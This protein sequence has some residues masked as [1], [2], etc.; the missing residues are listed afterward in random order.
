MEFDSVRVPKEITMIRYFREGLKL[1]IKAE[2]DQRGREFNSFQELV[3]K[4]V[5]AEAKAAL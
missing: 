1:S 4:A 3:E 2:M 5:K